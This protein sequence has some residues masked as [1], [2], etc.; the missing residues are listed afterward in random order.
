MIKVIGRE[1]KEEDMMMNSAWLLFGWFVVLLLP[2]R[3]IK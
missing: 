1:K 3:S 2:K